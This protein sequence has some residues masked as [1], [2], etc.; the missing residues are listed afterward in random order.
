MVTVND[1]RLELLEIADRQGYLLLDDCLDTYSFKQSASRAL[2]DLV[3]NGLMKVKPAP[4][5]S[6]K[7]KVWEITERG[8][9]FTQQ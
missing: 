4:E 7:K 3:E 5:I 9:I 2:S 8:K 1:K 6:R